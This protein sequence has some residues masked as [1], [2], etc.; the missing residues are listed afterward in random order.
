[1]NAL[2]AIEN[3]DAGPAAVDNPEL[4]ESLDE[5]SFR[6]F[7]TKVLACQYACAIASI[8][9]ATMVGNEV[10]LG[11]LFLCSLQYWFSILV[12]SANLPVQNEEHCQYYCFQFRVVLPLIMVLI[13]TP[14][15]VR[16]NS[17]RTDEY[18][19]SDLCGGEN[20]ARCVSATL[21]WPSVACFCILFISAAG[22]W[23]RNCI[24][25]IYADNKWGLQWVALQ[26]I[27]LTLKTGVVQIALVTAALVGY[28][29]H[30]LE[31]ILA[32]ILSNV[33]NKDQ[34]KYSVYEM[35]HGEQDNEEVVQGAIRGLQATVAG[36]A[37]NVFLMQLMLTKH[38]LKIYLSD[39][40]RGNVT[41]LEYFSAFLQLLIVASIAAM[42]CMTP[43]DI[44]MGFHRGSFFGRFLSLLILGIFI[45]AAIIILLLVYFSW[46]GGTSTELIRKRHSRVT[47][48][49]HSLAKAEAERRQLN[50]SV[51]ELSAQTS[52]FVVEMERRASEVT[53]SMESFLSMSQSSFLDLESQSSFANEPCSNYAR[54]SSFS[55]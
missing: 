22:H 17:T 54:D 27:D 18:S 43:G 14:T 39:V 28:G 21:A 37:V 40:V 48:M 35:G 50:A 8:V 4:E 6:S 3:N 5:I 42:V 55:I 33:E 44:A 31:E 46:V 34:F 45:P 1:M 10:L 16:T 7:S 12:W 49:E 41:W 15:F 52:Q 26:C 20:M 13:L 38:V 29:S 11:Y 19:T 9:Y 23:I 36:F 53:K 51:T 25:T 47:K 2:L 24:C 30:T 32:S